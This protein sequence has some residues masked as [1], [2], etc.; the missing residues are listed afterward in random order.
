[1]VDR[2]C[3]RPGDIGPRHTIHLPIDERETRS[4][5]VRQRG[6]WL[7]IRR[8]RRRGG[9]GRLH[10]PEYRIAAL[11]IARNREHVAVIR[12]D[13]DQRVALRGVR[14]GADCVGKTRWCRSARD[15]HCPHDGRDR[16]GPPPPSGNSPCDWP[17][18]S[19]WLWWSFRPARVRRRRPGRDRPHSA[20]ARARTVRAGAACCADRC[21]RSRPASTHRRTAAARA[22]IRRS[23]CGHRA[24][25][26]CAAGIPGR[27]G[28]WGR[29]NSRPP[30]STTSRPSPVLCRATSWAAMSISVAPAGSPPAPSRSRFGVCA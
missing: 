12:R 21:A 4:V 16:F 29:R 7:A 3:S 5:G 25:V 20:C 18:A 11:R 6:V 26:P 1:M 13:E 23:G 9:A 14:G 15:R 28:S 8:Q 17:G 27:A 24:G 22:S 19:A 2:S 10:Q 30:P